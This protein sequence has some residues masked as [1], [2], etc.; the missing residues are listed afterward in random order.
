LIIRVH[1]PTN[2][3]AVKVW[4]TGIVIPIGV[5]EEGVTVLLDLIEP[6]RPSAPSGSAAHSGSERINPAGTVRSPAFF[7]HV[8]SVARSSPWATCSQVPTP[9]SR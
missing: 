4:S 1:S 7:A 6:I 2:D 5:D 9:S 3:P 8:V